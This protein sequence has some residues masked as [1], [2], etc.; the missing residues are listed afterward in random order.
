[1]CII[2]NS[3]GL[4][5]AA[6]PLSTLIVPV[7]MSAAA[8]KEGERERENGY[9]IMERSHVK[10][11]NWRAERVRRRERGRE[12]EW[13]CEQSQ[14]HAGGWGCAGIVRNMFAAAAVLPILQWFNYASSSWNSSQPQVSFEFTTLPDDQENPQ[15]NIHTKYFCITYDRAKRRWCQPVGRWSVN[16]AGCLHN[17]LPGCYDILYWLVWPSPLTG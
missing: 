6:T 13:V 1:M 9:R 8:K 12:T 15:Q 10:E 11:R 16:R 14:W 17:H 5:L 4:L 3:N 2:H 7:W